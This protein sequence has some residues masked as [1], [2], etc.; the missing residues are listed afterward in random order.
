M[1]W[2][3]FCEVID[4]Y[5][6]LGVSWR[7]AA[8]L[9]ARGQTVRLWLD[10]A[11]HL[12]WLAPESEQ[13]GIQVRSWSDAETHFETGDVLL[14]AFGCR[15]PAGVLAVACARKPVRINLE[16]LSAEDY[17]ERMH[18][19]PSPQTCA[20]GSI[21]PTWFFYPGFTR[22]TGGL[23]REDDYDAR[24]LSFVPQAWLQKQGVMDTNRTFVSL[25]CYEPAALAA[26]LRLLLASPQPQHILVCAGRSAAAFKLALQ[27]CG[28]AAEQSASGHL[29]WTYLPFLSQDDFDHL[30]WSC[31]INFV[32][33]EDSVVRAIW[34]AKPFVW[35]IYPQ[36]DGAHAPKLAA[37]MQALQ[38]PAAAQAWQRLWNGLSDE[39]PSAANWQALLAC[40]A[41]Y[42]AMSAT[43]AAQNNLG[44]QLLAYAQA[45]K[46]V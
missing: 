25:F 6:D 38:L 11:S 31:D 16:Y 1:Q 37:F 20:D 39:R 24:R 33:G 10:D 4:N 18:G 17:V 5:G 46:Q 21:W 35:H 9:H 36:A 27:D 12:A 43:L 28:I 8:D 40:K 30:L 22:A 7:L 23:L 42:A 14:E 3:I 44:Q 34:A 32:R 29:Q 26:W 13:S 41:H 15:P 45:K 19:L 2:D